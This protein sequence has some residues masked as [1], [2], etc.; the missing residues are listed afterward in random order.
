[1][2]AHGLA[3]VSHAHPGNNTTPS[4][5]GITMINEPLPPTNKDEHSGTDTVGGL[6]DSPP[7][8]PPTL[9]L[10]DNTSSIH[11]TTDGI[12]HKAGALSSPS[13][14]MVAL[15][16]GD[17]LDTASPHD[18]AAATAPETPV[19]AAVG[20]RGH[21]ATHPTSPASP[22][23]PS[24]DIETPSRTAVAEAPHTLNG[25]HDNHSQL[26]DYCQHDEPCPHDAW[27]ARQA[28][29]SV[30][31]VGHIETPSDRIGANSRAASAPTSG[32]APWSQAEDEELARL[33]TARGPRRWPTIAAAMPGRTGKQCRERWHNQ[34]DPAV[35]KAPFTV[36]EV[37]TILVEHH[38][39]G[40]RWAEISRLLPGRTDNAVKNHW[41]A[42]LRR[43]F[44]R[45]VADEVRPKLA[46]SRQAQPPLGADLLR[47]SSGTKF[48]V[49]GSS[50]VISSTSRREANEQRGELDF[51]LSGPLLEKALAACV[52]GASPAP[53]EKRD[54]KG[55]SPARKRQRRW[56]VP[57]RS[58]AP[59]VAA[60]AEQEPVDEATPPELPSPEIVTKEQQQPASGYFFSPACDTE[61]DETKP[62]TAEEEAEAT[63]PVVENVEV[64]SDGGA[65]FGL[66]PSSP[67]RCLATP[68]VA[69]ATPSKKLG[70]SGALA[71]TSVPKVREPLRGGEL[72]S[73]RPLTAFEQNAA[74]AVARE[75]WERVW[76]LATATWQPNSPRP[77]MGAGST[78]SVSAA[79]S[80]AAGGSASGRARRWTAEEA[81]RFGEL[82][83][84][85]RKDAVRVAR[86][87]G[88]G[89]TVGDV[90]AFY[91]G[92][93]KQTQAYSA[94]K[95]QLKLEA[96]P[97]P[98]STRS[99]AA[100]SSD[101]KH[102]LPLAGRGAR[103]A[104][105]RARDSSVTNGG[106]TGDKNG[107]TPSWDTF[108]LKPVHEKVAPLNA[109]GSQQEQDVD[110]DDVAVEETSSA[111]LLL[112]N[113]AGDDLLQEDESC[114]LE[115]VRWPASSVYAVMCG[116]IVGFDGHEWYVARDG[117]T[118]AEV[119]S[120]F[121]VAA[122]VVAAIN[123]LARRQ[124]DAHAS[125]V[126]RSTQLHEGTMLLLPGSC[127]VE[128]PTED[129]LRSREGEIIDYMDRRWY[130]CRE[131]ETIDDIAGFGALLLAESH[132]DEPAEAQ[133]ELAD[134]LAVEAAAVDR[135]RSVRRDRPLPG[136]TALP[137]PDRWPREST[138][139]VLPPRPR[140]ADDVAALR[141]GAVLVEEPSTAGSRSTKPSRFRHWC[142]ARD[143][144]TPLA[145]ARRYGVELRALQRTN[146][147]TPYG[148]AIRRGGSLDGG[149][150]VLLPSDVPPPA[151]KRGRNLGDEDERRKQ[152]RRASTSPASSIAAAT[153][154]ACAAC[155][156]LGGSASRC[157]R[158]LRHSA[159][160][161]NVLPSLG[162]R[163]RVR[164]LP[165][166]VFKGGSATSREAASPR[167]AKH[168]R[169]GAS[170]YFA[171]VT[172]VTLLGDDQQPTADAPP[173][174]PRNA[175]KA[176]RR[177]KVTVSYDDDGGDDEIDWPD[178]D[179]VLLPLQQT[180]L[181]RSAIVAPHQA[182]LV[183]RSFRFEDD[184]EHP[185]AIYRVADVFYSVEEAVDGV[186]VQ[187]VDASLEPAPPLD[188]P[189]AFEYAGYA[190]F[191]IKA[192]LL[193]DA[194]RDERHESKPASAKKSTRA[195][196]GPDSRDSRAAKDEAT[197]TTPRKR[198]R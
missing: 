102:V 46:L 62:D 157:R 135:L 54:G 82:M 22:D 16:Q 27:S 18:L 192:R 24:V 124:R 183:G 176:M 182:A 10:N 40:N 163:I 178:P 11:T 9:R 26:D 98:V 95:T 137:L 36:D 25:G 134:R 45:F 94:L 144:D 83:A 161:Y 196:S 181:A 198:R 73:A 29:P 19:R 191:S 141:R 146:E 74:E 133:R 60:V 80:I 150:P 122:D 35:S 129:R 44:E 154:V 12:L 64:P 175:E 127:I 77:A 185:A 88:G 104:A 100:D 4:A 53:S 1:M 51:E 132:H 165:E 116:E 7:L 66:P 58:I 38:K 139:R 187:Y 121:A 32:S 59:A 107:V 21:A 3:G 155:R 42:S 108:K 109:G 164:W 47:E 31:H 56:Q 186:V 162:S 149:T 138:C 71:D 128:L 6:L 15:W 103:S 23:E 170:W 153:K 69:P 68:L 43:R 184:E 101:D 86:E 57:P 130:V 84:R 55:Q 160:P 188:E 169:Q 87:L 142:A 67:T 195:R 52:G 14:A 147:A 152:P 41:N 136:R 126:K 171:T 96:Q 76:P 13:A 145:I 131:G 30:T 92:R 78:P 61:H 114:V 177:S 34:L 93:W 2:M 166:P 151:N 20:E 118:V 158:E 113:N 5:C 125:I 172:A 105:K 90:L 143:G 179:A 115:T 180:N 159:P 190:E 39:R 65:A 17:R 37:R 48:P 49:L 70:R 193:P 91:Y 106:L 75:L 123:T 111:L 120:R 110:D 156:L 85:H 63:P 50:S 119:C 72:P 8:S 117:D 173:R 168:S 97:R 28:R 33:V 112:R 194:K 148:A 140:D 89:R 167:D 79:G 81:Q 197:V 189:D 99:A 174:S